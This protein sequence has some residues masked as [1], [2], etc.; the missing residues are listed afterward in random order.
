LARHIREV[1][2]VCPL[3]LYQS[4]HKPGKPTETA[5]HHV[6]TYKGSS[7]KQ[8]SYFSAFL[9]IER[10]SDSTSWDISKAAKPHVLGGTL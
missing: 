8:V 3:Q 1:T 9:D 5:M 4:V 10:A 6:Y 2:G 7:G